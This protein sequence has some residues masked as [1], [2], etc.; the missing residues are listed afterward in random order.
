[1]LVLGAIMATETP[2]VPLGI[3]LFVRA[4]WRPD[5]RPYGSSV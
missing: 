4:G 5:S 3:V 1:M 2:A